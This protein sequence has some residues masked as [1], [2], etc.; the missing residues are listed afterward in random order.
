VIGLKGTAPG[1]QG[2]KC[3]TVAELGGE[4]IDKSRLVHGKAS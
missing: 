3:L 4:L 1:Q 2:V